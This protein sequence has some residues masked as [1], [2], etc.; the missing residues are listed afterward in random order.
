M[1]PFP[2]KYVATAAAGIAGMVTVSSPL[3]RCMPF[4]VS[5]LRSSSRMENQPSTTETTYS[6]G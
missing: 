3:I 2:R 1:H 4:T 5:T 6:N